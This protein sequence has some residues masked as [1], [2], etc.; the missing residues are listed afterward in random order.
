MGLILR[1]IK[2]SEL[3]WTEVDGN[4]SQ[5][6]Y[7]VALSGA[8]L[9]FYTNNGVDDVLKRTIDLSQV[10]GFAGVTVMNNGTPV[11]T[12]V[13]ELNFF[14]AGIASITPDG[15]IKVDIEIEGGGSGLGFPYTGSAQITGSSESVNSIGVGNKLYINWSEPTV[16]QASVTSRVIKTSS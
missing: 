7:D 8:Q 5:L 10:P 15:G 1:N 9:Q 13:T 3:T 16:P 6:L 11:L 14:G 4:F 2:G 12:G